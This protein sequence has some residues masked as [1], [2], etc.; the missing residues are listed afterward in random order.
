MAMSRIRGSMGCSGGSGNRCSHV[1]RLADRQESMETTITEFDLNIRYQ[2][3]RFFAD[4][5]RAPSARELADLLNAEQ[6]K[7]R[8][9]FHKL[10]ERH[11]IF[12]EPGTDTIRMANPF[13]AI[14][15]KFKVLSGNREW[16]ANCAWDSLG[17]AAALNIDVQIEASYPDIQET[18]WLQVKNG[19]VDGKDHLVYFPLP[20]RQWYDDLVFT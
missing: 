17:I 14:P 1:R 13:S 18:V 10:H 3:Y 16:W 4:Q 7:V 5:C 11:M 15:T 2:I 19:L 9:S 8:A 20:C 12:L 6:E